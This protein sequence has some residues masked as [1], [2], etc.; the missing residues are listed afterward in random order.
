MLL[1]CIKNLGTFPCLRCLVT[2]AEIPALGTELD[3]Q[4]RQSAEGARMDSDTRKCQVEH[5]QKA[6]YVKGK[7]I[8]SKQ[9]DDLLGD[10]SLV[11][12]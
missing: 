5:A 4:K 8:T 9:V 7:P 2:K 6:I 12:T 3:I 10:E 1:A 11:P